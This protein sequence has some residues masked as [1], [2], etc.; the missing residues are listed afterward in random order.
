MKKYA[1]ALL[2][3]SC[4]YT[5]RAQDPAFTLLSLRYDDTAKVDLRY[6]A[7]RITEGCTTTFDK[8]KAVVLWTNRNFSWNY[9]DYKY[10]TAKQIICQRGGNCNEQA[11]VVRVLLRE[12]AVQTRRTHE[13][14]IQPEKKQRQQDA[15]KRV[16]EIGNR[17][18]VFGLRHNDHVWIEFYDAEKKEW[19]PADP[20]L[21]L[22][23]LESWLRSRIGF[24]PRISHAIIPSRDMLVPISVFALNPNGTIAEDRSAYYLIESFNKVYGNKLEGLEA[25]KNWKDSIRF[26]EQKCRDAIEGNDNL[27]KYTSDIKEIKK[28]YASLRKEFYKKEKRN[29]NYGKRK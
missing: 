15:E 8:V 14:N 11:I 10:R 17:G 2:L 24:E 25:W 19:V 3:F 21:G 28:I 7:T 27:H 29:G 26:I 23:G 1:L 9:T 22:V 13:I 5:V 20:T 4:L 18:S 12:L 6:M 16:A